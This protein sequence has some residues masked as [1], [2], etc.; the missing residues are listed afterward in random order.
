M[1]ILSTLRRNDSAPT[2]YPN[3]ECIF[4]YLALGFFLMGVAKKYFLCYNNTRTHPSRVHIQFIS[5]PNT[6][7]ETILSAERRMRVLTVGVSAMVSLYLLAAFVAEPLRGFAAAANENDNKV[8]VTVT[9]SISITCDDENGDSNGDNDNLTLGS[10]TTGGDTGLY[11]TSRDYKCNV[12]TNDSGGYYISW[13]V[14]TGSGGASTGYMISQFEDTIAPFRANATD[15]N[16]ALTAAVSWPSTGEVD[17]NEAAWGAR[18]SSTSA[19]FTED[20]S[21]VQIT[22]TEWGGAGSDGD[23]ANEEWA[24][25]ASGTAVIFAS[26]TDEPTDSG[27]DHY[28]GFR[29]EIGSSRQQAT[30][31]YEVLVDFTATTDS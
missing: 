10:I 20:H 21:S 1:E 30:G 7:M 16:D 12:Q 19:S 18:L 22:S 31:V 9:S 29:A 28:I 4:L 27:D 24:R 17:A 8:S 2:F 3:P 25:V 23:S 14:D 13:V 5:F 15:N 26:S 11:A 6:H